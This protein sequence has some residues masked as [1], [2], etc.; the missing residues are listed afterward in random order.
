VTNENCGLKSI[1]IPFFAHRT[2]N[3]NY[4]FCALHRLDKVS[5]PLDEKNHPIRFF[6]CDS[7][8]NQAVQ[9][10]DIEKT[11]GI[12]FVQIFTQAHVVVSDNQSN[13]R[14]VSSMEQAIAYILALGVG[15]VDSPNNVISIL[16]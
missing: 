1:K 5:F 14:F 10:W 7:I 9:I 6:I 2:K 15:E 13:K 4:S 12:Q 11:W 3:H 8:P 16:Q